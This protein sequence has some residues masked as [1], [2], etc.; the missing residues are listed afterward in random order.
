[1]GMVAA[2]LAAVAVAFCVL[3]LLWLLPRRAA[4]TETELAPLM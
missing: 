4:L 1:M 3:S 2:P